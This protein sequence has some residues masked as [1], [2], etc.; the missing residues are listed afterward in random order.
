MEVG[1][2]IINYVFCGLYVFYTSTVRPTSFMVRSCITNLDSDSELI[3]QSYSV[4]YALPWEIV[5]VKQIKVSSYYC[6]LSLLKRVYETL[7]V[8]SISEPLL[9]VLP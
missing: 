9:S 4:K 1:C 5:V 8:V 2:V 6:S 7:K 3:K